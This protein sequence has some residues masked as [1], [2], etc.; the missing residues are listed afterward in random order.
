M[1]KASTSTSRRK[2]ILT[3][4]RVRTHKGTH[5]GT[6]KGVRKGTRK[7]TGRR[8]KSSGIYCGN[9]ELHDGILSGAKT[10]GTAYACFKKG[11][12]VGLNQS[13]DREYRNYRPR[14]KRRIYCGTR[15]RPLPRRYAYV[16]SLP[17]CLQK[18]VA[19]GKRLR[20]A[21]R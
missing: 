14:D 10:W 15:P 6:R 12:G 7:R 4:V 9:N 11:V 21:R 19:V 3:R 17:Q 5:K 16:G 20:W 1:V 18:G 2:P 13:L 8:R